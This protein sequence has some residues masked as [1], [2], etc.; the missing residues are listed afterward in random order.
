M[1]GLPDGGADGSTLQGGTL[2]KLVGGAP[3]STGGSRGG[4]DGGT[5]TTSR[6]GGASSHDGGSAGEGSG[7]YAGTGGGVAA[8]ATGGPCA[9]LTPEHGTYL[10]RKT[11]TL[12]S[13]V[14][15]VMGIASD[16]TG[17]WILSASEDSTS[18]DIVHY[19]LSSGAITARFA[20]PAF[21]D[22]AGSGAYGIETDTQNVWISVS[23]NTNAIVRLDRETGQ[24]VDQFGSPSTLGPSD[25]AWF[26]G[27]LLVSTGTGELYTLF[28]DTSDRA[29]RVHE[30]RAGL[31]TRQ[32]GG[33]L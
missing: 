10:A 32:W 2:A 5:S 28:A 31:G 21:F 12:I 6:T 15:N 20:P 11:R 17:L 1:S 25:L 22:P 18:T 33:Y 23:G 30:L 29:A 27:D 24:V 7:G 9:A 3:G 13:P 4:V 16:T 14:P 26:D 19:D 8:G